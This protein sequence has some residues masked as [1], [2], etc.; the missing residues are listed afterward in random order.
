MRHRY[1]LAAHTIGLFRRAYGYA[2]VP[3]LYHNGLGRTLI[4]QQ[5]YV[6]RAVEQ[7]RRVI[8]HQVAIHAPDS[9]CSPLHMCAYHTVPVLVSYQLHPCHVYLRQCRAAPLS[10][11]QHKK[12]YGFACQPL[13]LEAG[14]QPPLRTIQAERHIIAALFRVY[15]DRHD[16]P[17]LKVVVVSYAAE[18]HPDFG[19]DTGAIFH[20]LIFYVCSQ[21]ACLQETA[22]CLIGQH[23]LREPHVFDGSIGYMHMPPLSLTESSGHRVIT[24][25]LLFS[26]LVPSF[27]FTY[28]FICIHG[29]DTLL[30]FRCLPI[31]FDSLF[32]SFTR[33]ASAV[34]QASLSEMDAYHSDN[35]VCTMS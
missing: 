23:L 6:V 32:S 31:M 11:F 10:C 30:V 1:V 8:L 16:C 20:A 13:C 3:V 2:A 18:I 19:T 4:R 27:I 14:E 25:F 17:K 22:N 26:V 12:S 15:H 7:V 29:Q 28:D 34:S 33:S 24:L 9:P 21:T 35:I 5:L